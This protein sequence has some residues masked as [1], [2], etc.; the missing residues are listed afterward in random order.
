[1]L[2]I[3]GGPPNPA[4]PSPCV[5][6]GASSGKGGGSTKGRKGEKGGKDRWFKSRDTHVNKWL[7]IGKMS[8]MR[9][10]CERPLKVRRPTAVYEQIVVVEMCQRDAQTCP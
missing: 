4:F 10:E 5:L 9:T 8:K 6:G 3:L 2:Q 7:K 1:M